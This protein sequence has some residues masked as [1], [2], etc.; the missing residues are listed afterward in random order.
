MFLKS[1]F[2]A[3]LATISNIIPLSVAH[4]ILESKT[5]AGG[6]TVDLIHRAST[7]PPSQRTVN[8]LRR[9]LNRH[10]RLRAPKWSTGK[11]ET[12]ILTTPT[13]EFL[14]KY[15]I[16]TPPVSTYGL[17]DTGSDLTWTQ[18]PPCV[19]CFNQ[20]L[21]LFYPNKSS[22]Y[23]RIPCKDK[24]CHDI[25]MGSCSKSRGNCLY[26]QGYGDGSTTEGEL[27][28]DTLT[29]GSGKNASFP[30]ITFGCGFKNIGIYSE[31]ESGIVGLGAGKYSLVGQLY[32]SIQGKFSHCLVSMS[33]ETVHTSKL[34]FGTAA[35]VSGAGVVSTPLALNS[36]P[37][38]LLTLQGITIGNHQRL[39]VEEEET[40]AGSSKRRG[41]P[42]EGNIIIDSGTTL[43]FLPYR[44][45]QKVERVVKSMI[46]LKPA[47]DP[48]GV[49]DVC[50]YTPKGLNF[51]DMVVHFKGA[52]V[53]LKTENSF[54]MTD[55][56]TTCLAFKQSFDF[57]IFGNL[58]QMNFL[59]GY[60]LQNR[61]VSFKPSD[62][63][64]SV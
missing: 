41:R 1:I 29:L 35:I 18:C 43:T 53:R 38:Y 30:N 7:E 23:K 56:V 34:H 15:S 10:N 3:Y 54:I 57:P 51:S 22:T 37:F 44:L 48:L 50:Y 62:C 52:D 28:R 63:S 20:T 4:E 31:D 60:D 42:A 64:R 32:N 61:T 58:A 25:Q 8:A 17:L 33:S 40:T 9:S 5:S 21:P 59:V 45:Y 36:G 13:G 24:T 49:L 47:R 6:F 55:N 19:D 14:M 39:R 11:T 46:K 16:G 27:A 26:S 2:V 12:E